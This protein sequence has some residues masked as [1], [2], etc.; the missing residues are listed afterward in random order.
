MSG[1]RRVLARLKKNGAP[2]GAP[3]V[4]PHYPMAPLPESSAHCHD[5]RRRAQVPASAGMRAI[6]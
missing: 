5:T 2:E 3:N 4:L 6:D 1:F